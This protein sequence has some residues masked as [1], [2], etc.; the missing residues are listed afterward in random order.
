MLNTVRRLPTEAPVS[1]PR[2]EGP[3]DAYS[4]AV[5]MVVD[6]VGPAVRHYSHWC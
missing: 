1:S 5:A 6:R 2:D 3:L 4:R